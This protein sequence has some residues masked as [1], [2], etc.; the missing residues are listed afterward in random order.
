M[1]ANYDWQTGWRQINLKFHNRDAAEMVAATHL[2]PAMAT[3][4]TAGLITAWFFVRK[5]HWWR[6]RYRPADE[7]VTDKAKASVENAL[8]GIREAGQLSAWIEVIYEPEIYAFGGP[9]GIEVA[10]ELFHHDSRHILHY[11]AT[12]AASRG[13][14]RRELSVLLCSTY[15]QPHKPSKERVR[16]RP[17]FVDA[18]GNVWI[19]GRGVGGD[20]KEWDIQPGASSGNL[21]K[22]FGDGKH[23]NVSIDGQ[24]THNPKGK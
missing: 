6:I 19:E 17:G 3:T 4:E 21:Q 12:S 24:V 5:G 10:H 20:L 18:Y 23:V 1:A 14:K 7:S 13:D 22:Q 11:L 15:W 9:Q 2:E 16:G 8:H